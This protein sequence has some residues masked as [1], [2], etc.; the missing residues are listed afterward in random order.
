MVCALPR[1]VWCV[2]RCCCTHVETSVC[3]ALL[4]LACACV[5]FLLCVAAAA[6][7]GKA[8]KESEEPRI[9][10]LDIR[11]GK[12]VSVQQH[13]N[14]GALGWWY[15]DTLLGRH[16]AHVGLLWCS[17]EQQRA[18]SKTMHH[19]LGMDCA[20]DALLAGWL[21]C[22]ASG[23]ERCSQLMARAYV[24]VASHQSVHPGSVVTM[25]FVN[26]LLPTDALYLEEIDVGEEKPR[27]VGR[28]APWALCCC[29]PASPAFGMCCS[30]LYDWGSCCRGSLWD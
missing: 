17:L 6:A 12:I 21:L 20:P 8:A 7:G 24:D 19:V 23:P 9:D 30:K 10:M 1:Q 4:L 13:P 16:A 22:I 15:T 2:A 5:A 11:V 27:Q 3:A 28:G 29:P 25:G 14:A 26:V 18:A